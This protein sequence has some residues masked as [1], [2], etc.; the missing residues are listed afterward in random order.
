[1]WHKK[2]IKTYTQLC[3]TCMYKHT[4]IRKGGKIPKVTSRFCPWN[5]ESVYRHY[6]FCQNR[7]GK[8]CDYCE[9]RS[10]SFMTHLR[11]ISVHLSYEFQLALTVH[12]YGHIFYLNTV[13]YDGRLFIKIYSPLFL[14]GSLFTYSTNS[15]TYMFTF[16]YLKKRSVRWSPFH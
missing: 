3:C 1:M 6:E 10:N 13:P 9:K 16:F 5:L 8:K 12:K 4:G 11:K 14:V 15:S 2:T 7:Q